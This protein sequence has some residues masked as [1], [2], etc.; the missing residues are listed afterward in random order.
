MA[1]E[2]V[3][4]GLF[5]K[6]VNFVRQPATPWT[7]LDKTGDDRQNL[8][9]QQLKAIVERK[10]HNELLRKREF[11]MLRKLRR[12][13]PQ[14]EEEVAG[15]P[16]FFNSSLPSMAPVKPPQQ[17]LKKI[18]DIEADMSM[19][20]WQPKAPGE[21]PPENL[22]Q[23]ALAT[24]VP[25]A[26]PWPSLAVDSEPARASTSFSTSKSL[27][28]DVAEGARD[29]GLEDAAMQFANAED[30]AAEATLLD[31]IAPHN[32]RHDH[33]DT[34]LT[35]FDFYRATGRANRFESLAVEFAQHFGRSAPQWFSMPELVQTTVPPP[36]VLPAA[37]PT[38]WSSPDALSRFAVMTLSAVKPRTPG[39][40]RLDWTLLEEIDLSAV[41]A[42]LRLLRGWRGQP[43][44]LQF[45]Q[46]E[47]LER[48]LQQATPAGEPAVDPAW[49]QL[50][51]EA[52]RVMG[53]VEAFDQVALDY[54]VTYEVSPPSWEPVLCTYTPVNAQGFP[55]I[56][57]SQVKGNVVDTALL[58]PSAY[59]QSEW[60]TVAMGLPALPGGTV[61]STALSGQ[62][63]GD[64]P[65]A[66]AQL[67][68]VC[69]DAGT[70]QINCSHLIRLDFA[71]AGALLN[72]ASAQHADKRTVQ[73]NDVHRL[74]APFFNVIG[75]PACATVVV[76]TD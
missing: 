29:V 65:P 31:A 41:D 16:S 50:R 26:P 45:I 51:M 7:E 70:L 64:A 46:P 55:A 75:I 47:K 36:A 56:D 67:A 11:G 23:A 72:W 15:H 57:F 20:W 27:A 33:A 58:G 74:L 28:V 59:R 66:L 3:P 14:A 48:V 60:H 21:A 40:W 63:S 37:R 25:A 32:G 2:D 4:G 53:Q 76:R 13:D 42:L 19:K 44:Q 9:R 30:A 43:V 34:W 68:A 18:A 61:V 24:P 73:F 39:Q 22:R 8:S 17:T 69:A 1:S 6:V 54:C 35:L 38:D 62:L 5:S 10:R 52:C 49:W 12:H 71:A